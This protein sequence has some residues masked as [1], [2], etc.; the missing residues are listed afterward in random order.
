[1]W[2]RFPRHEWDDLYSRCRRC[3]ATLDMIRTGEALMQCE[4]PVFGYALN[5]AKA[6]EIV[7]VDTRTATSEAERIL[8]GEADA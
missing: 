6:G 8:R 3:G 5:D 7:A 2:W 4:P 1:M